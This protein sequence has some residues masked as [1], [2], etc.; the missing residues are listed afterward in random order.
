MDEVV[1][2]ETSNGQPIVHQLA[3]VIVAA[4]AGFL[5]GKAAERLYDAGLEAYRVHQATS[6]L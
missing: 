4:V 5:A 6:K 2:V 3:K 1:V